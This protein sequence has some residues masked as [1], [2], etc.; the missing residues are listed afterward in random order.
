MRLNALLLEAD[1]QPA[2]PGKGITGKKY[3]DDTCR[4]RQRSAQVIPTEAKQLVG[5]VKG[6]SESQTKL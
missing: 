6:G 4:K 2:M 5:K 3:Q 1:V